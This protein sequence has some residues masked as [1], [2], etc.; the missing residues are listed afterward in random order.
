M[1]EWISTNEKYPDPGQKVMITVYNHVTK[2]TV[3]IPATYEPMDLDFGVAHQWDIGKNEDIIHVPTHWR[4]LTEV[5][6][7]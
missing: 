1:N 4:P 2:N 7:G 6:N 3:E 5:P